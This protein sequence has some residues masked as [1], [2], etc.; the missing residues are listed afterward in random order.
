MK[1]LKNS[2]VVHGSYKVENVS[3]VYM[4]PLTRLIDLVLA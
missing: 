2:T 3:G 1:D 4:V